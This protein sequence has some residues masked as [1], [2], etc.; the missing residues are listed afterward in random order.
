M[1]NP[2]EIQSID[3]K[4]FVSSSNEIAANTLIVTNSE[5]VLFVCSI[6]KKLVN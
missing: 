4:E 3:W 5:D 2:G 1:G 6:N